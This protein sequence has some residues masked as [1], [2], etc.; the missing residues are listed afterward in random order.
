MAMR[1]LSEKAG[2]ELLKWCAH[3]TGSL[4]RFH[5]FILVTQ[6]AEWREDSDIALD[7]LALEKW[8]CCLCTS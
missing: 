4:T 1:W 5:I 6:E 7:S 3:N 2:I 8:S